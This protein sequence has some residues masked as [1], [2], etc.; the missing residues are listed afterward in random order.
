MSI[1]SVY[2]TRA[3]FLPWGKSGIA[4]WPRATL[5]RVAAGNKAALRLYEA[6]DFSRIM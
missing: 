1:R 5:F 2:G 3:T 6:L 4:L